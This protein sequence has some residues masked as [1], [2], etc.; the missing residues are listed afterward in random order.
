M[1]LPLVQEQKRRRS[2]NRSRGPSREAGPAAR[3]LRPAA[4][5]LDGSLLPNADGRVHQPGAHPRG[6]ARC[7]NPHGGPALAVLLPAGC[8]R[9]ELGQAFIS[10]RLSSPLQ[11]QGLMIRGRRP[12]RGRK[13]LSLQH[14]GTAGSRGCAVSPRGERVT[15]C[16]ESASLMI[17]RDQTSR[18]SG[19]APNRLKGR[20]Y[21]QGAGFQPV[22]GATA[23]AGT[24]CDPGPH[25]PTGTMQCLGSIVHPDVCC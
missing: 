17:H 24:L 13:G 4:N 10:G 3:A 22:E 14:R 20:V 25:Q 18:V 21:L 2:L 5:R 11:P 8:C 1:H 6:C 16:F 23:A 9:F 19:K 12:G 15:C 7:G